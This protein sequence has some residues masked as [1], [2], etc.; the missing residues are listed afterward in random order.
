MKPDP[1]SRSSHKKKSRRLKRTHSKTWCFVY[2]LREASGQPVRYVGQTRQTPE[3]R[4]WW[5][6][7]DL[8]RCKNQ[9]LRLTPIK[10][11]LDGLGVPPV[12]EVIDHEGIWNISEA[13]WID[14]YRR[15]GEPLLNIASVVAG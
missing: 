1:H 9:G 6:L 3:M 13:V 15:Q 14:R 8:R 11:W 10:C 4:L 5:H 7:K 2:V 12:I